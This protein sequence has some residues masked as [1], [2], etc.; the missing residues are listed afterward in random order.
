MRIT[1]YGAT[2]EVTGSCY[3]VETD[4]V[5]LL[6]DCGMYQG[7]Q[8]VEARNFNDFAFDASTI[9]AVFVT[10]AHLDHTGRCEAR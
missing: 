3:L 5:R 7:G 4:H 6:V 1:F 10:H 8:L 9:D 2:R